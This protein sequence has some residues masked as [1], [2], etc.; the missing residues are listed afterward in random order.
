MS[1]SSRASYAFAAA[2]TGNF[3]RLAT[4]ADDQV[5]FQSPASVVGRYM[6]RREGFSELLFKSLPARF[7]D[8][9]D[10]ALFV[11]LAD[12]ASLRRSK[13]RP[14]YPDQW[15]RR[16]RLRLPVREPAI[17]NSPRVE[18]CLRTLLAWMTDDEW[19]FEFIGK[20][21]G[22]ATEQE[23]LFEWLGTKPRRI[24]LFSGGL[25]SFAGAVRDLTEYPHHHH[26]FVSGCTSGRQQHQQVK[27]VG[28]LR[29]AFSPEITHLLV[30]YGIRARAD[31][32][33]EERSQRTRGFVHLTLGVVTAQL[34]GALELALTENGIGAINLPY[35]AG[36]VGTANSRAVHPVTLNLMEAFAASVTGAPFAIRN[37]GLFRTKGELCAHPAF[38]QLG[39]LIQE[40]FTCD[41]FPNRV[42]DKP[43]CGRC[44]SCLLRRQALFHAGW[45]DAGERYVYDVANPDDTH[46]IGQMRSMT[47]Q[48]KSL[49]HWRKKG[50]AAFLAHF[51]QLHECADIL[52]AGIPGGRNEARRQLASLYARYAAEWLRFTEQHAVVEPMPSMAL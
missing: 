37:L 42:A 23:F 30:P 44:T 46:A 29:Q 16:I 25:D 31:G 13:Q 4:A 49:L 36:Q 51:P 28:G 19:E 9:L 34:C 2:D 5:V 21:S 17:W 12:R 8:W 40:T 7:A 38:A 24:C 52:A 47:A 48:V 39:H 20:P 27:Q 26:V 43:Q 10:I 33:A 1:K 41:G 3:V 35:N 18:E 22:S 11:Y 15:G 45:A 50:E 6:I 14:D 32:Q